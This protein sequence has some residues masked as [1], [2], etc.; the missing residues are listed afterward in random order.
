M[1]PNP[2]NQHYRLVEK[3]IQLLKANQQQ[4]PSL[5]E[6]ADKLGVSPYYL[7]RTFKEW[8]GI[9]PKRFLQYLT[10]E[11]AL[12]ALKQ[13]HSTT[14]ASLC[15]GL[16]GTSRLHDLMISCEAMTPG[17]IRQQGAGLEIYYGWGQTPVGTA[18]VAWTQR[19]ICQLG[20]IDNDQEQTIFQLKT[21]WPKAV[22]VPE[23][24]EAQRLLEKI[25]KPGTGDNEVRLLIKGT[26]FQLKVWEALINSAPADL[27]SYSDLAAAVGKPQAQR[28]IGSAMAA[29]RIGFLIP[30]HRVLRND[31]TIGQYR[32]GS[33]RK[34]ALLAWE[35]AINE[36]KIC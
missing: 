13:N 8:A 30:C 18:L 7:Q 34:Q 27:L 5:Q 9:S 20:F 32:W 35:S 29:N 21:E 22:F 10:K 16:S 11:H 6:L 33:T 25:F 23:N 15:C 24:G 12:A 26:N 2:Q 19:G 14:E 36:N 17:E 31:G 4:Q 1:T 3:A 28:A